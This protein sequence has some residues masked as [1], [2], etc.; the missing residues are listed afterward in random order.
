MRIKPLRTILS[1]SNKNVV[2]LNSWKAGFTAP[3][4]NGSTLIGLLLGIAVLAILT[5]LSALML[6]SCFRLN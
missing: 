6:V 2:E 1:C 5:A 4:S 3:K